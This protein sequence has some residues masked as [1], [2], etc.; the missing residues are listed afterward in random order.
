[1]NTY[2]LEATKNT[3]EIIFNP[4]AKQFIIQGKSYPENSKKF[5]LPLTEWILKNKLPDH[6]VIEMYFI[7]ISSSSVI[8]I[9]DLLRK[10]ESLNKKIIVKWTYEQG[11]DDMKNVGLNFQ[12]LCSLEF[13][14]IEIA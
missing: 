6:S 9:L 3:P 8:S 5:Y 1:M 13:D 2:S 11:D 10:V 7:Y 4:S 14:F 12:K